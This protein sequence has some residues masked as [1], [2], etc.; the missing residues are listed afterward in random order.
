MVPA[1]KIAA[2]ARRDASVEP[3]VSDE[4]RELLERREQLTERFA[5]MQS[6]IGGIFYEMAIRDHVRMDVL[7][8]KAAQLQRVDAELASVERALHGDAGP[9][10]GACSVCRTPYGADAQ[11]CS[12]CGHPLGGS[13]NGNGA[14]DTG[15]A[16]PANGN[17]A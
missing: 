17:G 4:R 11:F 3:L 7:T 2:K 6:A 15:A 10:V 13:A 9:A 12:R 16:P 14:G 5:V 1:E 8:G